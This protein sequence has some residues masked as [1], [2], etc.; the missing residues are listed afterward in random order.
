MAKSK[1]QKDKREIERRAQW[2][3]AYACQKEQKKN[4]KLLVLEHDCVLKALDWSHY[5]EAM[6]SAWL[7]EP[8]YRTRAESV[9]NSQTHPAAPILHCSPMPLHFLCLAQTQ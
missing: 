7:W 4:N 6:E 9:R 2:L 3:Q 8:S 1:T 5:L